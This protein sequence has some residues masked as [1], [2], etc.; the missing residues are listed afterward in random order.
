VTGRLIVVA[1]TVVG[2]VNIALFALWWSLI[3]VETVDPS[4]RSE[5]A[6]EALSLQITILEVVLAAVGLGLAI[7]GLFGY[8]S[9]KESAVQASLRETRL[10]VQTHLGKLRDSGSLDIAATRSD[11]PSSGE[12]EVEREERAL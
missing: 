6:L 3:R 11:I 7:L 8:Q 5:Y 12:L 4:D 2:T 10:Q 1:G 9:V